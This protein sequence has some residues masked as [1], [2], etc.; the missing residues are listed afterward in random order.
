MPGEHKA[1]C[2][3]LASSRRKLL[4]SALFLPDRLL[5]GHDL[6]SSY[7]AHSSHVSHLPL[8][9]LAL[10][11]EQSWIPFPEMPFFPQPPVHLPRSQRAVRRSWQPGLPPLPSAT[12]WL[13]G[14]GIHAQGAN[15]QS[16]WESLRSLQ[17]GNLRLHFRLSNL[18]LNYRLL[19]LINP[20]PQDGLT[21]S[22]AYP[23]SSVHPS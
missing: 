15:S 7:K 23:F 16:H 20:M 22:H 8:R 13:A 6:T 2:G 12:T 3:F 1:L 5:H 18:C 11:W 9:V 4:F 21:L 10:V 17:P 19:Q 14:N